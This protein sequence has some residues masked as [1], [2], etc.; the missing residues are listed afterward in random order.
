MRKGSNSMRKE[1]WLVTCQ[2]STLV[3]VT[4]SLKTVF[5]SEL[6]STRNILDHS[7]VSYDKYLSTCGYRLMELTYLSTLIFRNISNTYYL[8]YPV[9]ISCKKVN[10][11]CCCLVLK[12]CLTL[13]HTPWTV[14]HKSPLSMGFS[15]KNTGVGCHALLQGIC[16]TQGLN[17]ESLVSPALAGRFFITSTT[18]E[19]PLH[20]RQ[21]LYHWAER[22]A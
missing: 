14:A 8:L 21:F 6:K 9:S 1:G 12:S 4:H 10:G 17:P 16:P 5:P 15:G 13:C 20:C 22:E 7:S 19:A 18:W 2:N 3:S 11:C